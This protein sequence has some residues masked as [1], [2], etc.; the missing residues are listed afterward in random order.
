[1]DC[2]SSS[3]SASRKPRVDDAWAVWDEAQLASDATPLGRAIRPLAALVPAGGRWFAGRSIG[4]TL[5]PRADR[6]RNSGGGPARRR[7]PLPPDRL[8]DGRR[9]PRRSRSG[10]PRRGRA[11]PGPSL[12][13]ASLPPAPPVASRTTRSPADARNRRCPARRPNARPRAG[14]SPWRRCPVLGPGRGAAPGRADGRPAPAAGRVRRRG[15][16]CRAGPAADVGAAPADPAPRG[17][18]RTR[19]SFHRRRQQTAPS[20]TAPPERSYR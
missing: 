2:R 3:C 16:P 19:P 5:R 9:R 17:R 7:G 11:S 20:P 15:H 4:R 12:R 10:R 1:M 14:R 8:P 18:T 13:P 6:P